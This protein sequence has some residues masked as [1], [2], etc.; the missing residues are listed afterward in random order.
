MSKTISAPMA[1]HLAGNITTLAT[2]WKVT[3]KDGTILGFTNH[4]A[5]L[6]VAGVTYQSP[7]GYTPTNITTSA[8][9]EVDN[10]DAKAI[11]S[12][13]G[14]T[15]VE[16]LNGKWDY[17]TL[18]FF[19]VNY[20]DLTMGTVQLRKGFLGEVK[21]GRNDI[22]AEIRGLMDKY[23]N[24]VVELYSAACRADLGDSACTVNLIP[25]THTGSVTGV[26]DLRIFVD[27]ALTGA[28]N[29]YQGGL[30]TWTSGLN[31]GRTMEVRTWILST[32]TMA[33]V[34]PMAAAIQVGD[35]YSVYEGCSKTLTICR[36]KFNNVINF[37]GE[38]FIPQ[39]KLLGIAEGRVPE[40][41]GK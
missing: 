21:L 27:T 30:L 31:I 18:E 10:L 20:A 24:E 34:L 35:T 28:D 5:N 14:M 17:A 13:G 39:N 11:L 37:R 32:K 4:T 33:L 7:A 29:L 15:K 16:I 26:T 19:L 3:A 1:L 41:G 23:T 40:G 9:L 6:I 2:C 8:G 36:T 25:F 38:P 12:A 22:E